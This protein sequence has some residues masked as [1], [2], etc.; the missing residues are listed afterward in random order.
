M[1]M[2]IAESNVFYCILCLCIVTVVLL[3][4]LAIWATIS[5]NTL[6]FNALP[7]FRIVRRVRWGRWC[8]VTWLRRPKSEAHTLLQMWQPQHGPLGNVVESA[9]LRMR[10]SSAAWLTPTCRS[11]VHP[12]RC[13]D[14]WPCL[15]LEFPAVQLECDISSM[16]T[17]TWSE[18]PRLFPHTAG[19]PLLLY[20][21]MMFA[22]FHC[23]GNCCEVHAHEVKRWSRCS[24]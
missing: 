10:R 24:R 1:Y 9:C 23:W 17:F 21:V 8:A 3:L 2:Y 4:Y 20:I 15:L 5:L 13:C 11:L 16:L 7:C 12:C 22:S 14:T 18:I 19:S 6:H